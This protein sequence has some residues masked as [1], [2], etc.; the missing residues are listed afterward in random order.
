[1]GRSQSPKRL[2]QAAVL[3]GVTLIATATSAFALYGNGAINISNSYVDYS[4]NIKWYP[5]SAYV[6]YGHGGM[7][8]SGYLTDTKCNGDWVY[9]SA[10]VSGYD[11]TRLRENRNGCGSSN[12]VWDGA[13]EVY[14]YQATMVS[15]GTVKVCQSD[16]FWDTCT[17]EYMHR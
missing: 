3:A 17:S 4:G 14:D 11:Y 15:E 1:M 16:A 5:N 12:R 2:V 9:V 7:V 10:Q 6:D 8:V 13:T